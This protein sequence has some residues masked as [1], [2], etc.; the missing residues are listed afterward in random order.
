MKHNHGQIVSADKL[1]YLET[2]CFMKSFPTEGILD[3]ALGKLRAIEV[4]LDY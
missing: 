2:I 1:Q 4:N 3:A